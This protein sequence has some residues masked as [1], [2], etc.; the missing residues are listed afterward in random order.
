MRCFFGKTLKFTLVNFWI[1]HQCPGGL[2]SLSLSARL[3]PHNSDNTVKTVVNT[4]P[5][6]PATRQ[7][8]SDEENSVN[9]AN[10][11][12]R[13]PESEVSLKADPKVSASNELTAPTTKQAKSDEENSV[14]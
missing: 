4:V 6:D 7:A 8:Q 11:E 10:D 14:N 3:Q 1:W 12:K 2:C 9:S 5:K 13:T